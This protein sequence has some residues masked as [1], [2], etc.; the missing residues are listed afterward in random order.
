ML[1]FGQRNQQ[2]VD[3]TTVQINTATY[4]REIQSTAS[5]HYL[6]QQ[7]ISV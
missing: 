3:N 7:C 6:L 2:N 1:T 4:D 5:F